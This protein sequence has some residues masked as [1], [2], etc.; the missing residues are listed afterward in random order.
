VVV[1]RNYETVWLGAEFRRG[2]ESTNSETVR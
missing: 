2:A 1:Q